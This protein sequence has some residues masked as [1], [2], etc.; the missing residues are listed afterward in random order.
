MM[1]VTEGRPVPG[2]T[3][4][5]A[6]VFS[7][8]RIPDA[9]MQASPSPRT[10]WDA[11]VPAIARHRVYNFEV[12][13]THTYIADGIRVHNRSTLSYID[14]DQQGEL[15]DVF[16]DEDGN[17][18][19]ITRSDDGAIWTTTGR[20]DPSDPSGNTTQVT[21]L[22]QLGFDENGNP[23]QDARFFLQQ[24]ETWI[25]D[26]NGD[27]TLSGIVIDDNYWLFGDEVGGGVGNV[28]TPFILEA[29]GIGSVFGRLTAGTLIDTFVQN[30]AEGGFN[31]LHHSILDATSTGDTAAF[32]AVD[33]FTDFGIDLGINAVE[34]SLS[35]VSELIM[36]EIFDSADLEGIPGAIMEAVVAEGIDYV[37]SA[38]VGTLLQGT[39]V[40]EAFD[41]TNYTIDNFVGNLPAVI[42]SAVLNELLPQAET[43]EGQIASSLASIFTAG[44]FGGGVGLLGFIGPLLGPALIG[45]IVGKI[46]DAIF[47]K[48][49]QAFAHL[50]F[51]INRG[52]WDTSF[53]TD[54]DGGSRE[55][56][57]QLGRAVN[58]KIN[59]VVEAIG[60]TS[61]NYD[62]IA[63]HRIG[64]YEEHWRNNANQN[65]RSG[66][67]AVVMSV[68][69]DVIKLM[70][71]DDGDLKVLRALDLANLETTLAGMSAQD[72]FTHIYSRMRF[73]Q[74][75]QYYL[76]NPEAVNAFIEAAPDS[77]EARAW[78]ATILAANELG[79]SD[80]YTANGNA[81][82]NFFA[83]GDGADVID[84]AGGNDEIR[85]YGGDDTLIGG[86]GDDEL[87]GGVGADALDGGAGVDTASYDDSGVAV[88]VDLST[89][90]GS[91]GEAA[92]DTYVSIE[93]LE[94]SVHGDD[95]T[96]DDAA[97][98]I[99]GNAGDDL[100]H[101]HG[102]DDI[103]RGDAGD[104]R[105]YGDLGADLTHAGAD[106]LEGGDGDDILHGGGGI[107]TVI[108]GAGHDLVSYEFA[109]TGVRISLADE[110]ARSGGQIEYFSEIEGAMG[111]AFG[112][113]LFGD[114]GANTFIG[115][116]GDDRIDGGAGSDTYVYTLG[117][118][119]DLIVDQDG[120]SANNDTLILHG[121][122]ADDVR[123]LVD[124]S[125]DLVI[126]FGNGESIFV[127]GQFAENQQ[128][129]L[130]LIQFDDG[131][132]LGR[133]EIRNKAA[134]DQSATGHVVG[135]DRIETYSHAE[136]DGSYAIHDWDDNGRTDRL[137]FTDLT[138]SQVTFGSN[139]DKDLILSTPGGDR[140]T[141]IGHFAEHL[142]T[143]I[144]EIEFSDG[145]VLN[146]PDIRNRSVAD[147]AATGFVFGTDFA[148][149]YIHT[150]GD[151]SYTITDWDDNGR[152]DRLT[153]T[154]VML[155]DV[156]FGW[157]NGGHLQ[158]SLANGERITVTG[159]FLED[160][161]SAIEE[162][163]FDDGTVLDAAAIRAR[164]MADQK[165]SGTVRGTDLADSYVHTPG[166]GSYTIRDWDDNGRTDRLTLTG[167]TPD[168]VILGATTGG[169]LTVALPGGDLIT[170][171]GQFDDAGQMGI[172][173]IAFDDGSELDRAAIRALAVDDQRGQG[174]IVGTELADTY[175]HLAG[176]GYLVLHDRGAAGQADTLV[177]ADTASSAVQFIR[178]GDSLRIDIGTGETI[179]V[180]GHFASNEFGLEAITFSDGVSLAR[181]DIPALLA[182]PA[183]AGS[184]QTGTD[185]DEVYT[186]TRGD[187]SYSITD[188][189]YWVGADR[190]TFADTTAD[191]VAIARIGNDVRI[192]LDNGEEITLV[193]Q[194]DTDRRHGVESIEFA[195]GVIWTERMLREEMVDAEAEAGYVR[196]T[197]LDETYVHTRGDGSYLI[198]DY[199]YWTGADRLRLADATAD[200][201]TLSR[202]GND[203]EITLDNGETITLVRQLDTDRRHGVETVEFSDGTVWTERQLRERM[204][205]DLKAQTI[206]TGTENDETYTHTTGDGSWVLSDYDYWG[207]AD[208]LEFSDVTAADVDFERLGNDVV[209]RLSMG[210]TVTLDRQLQTD[211][212]MGVETLTFADGTTM[213]R[214]AIRNRVVEDAK[215]TGRVTGTE[216]DETYVH[217]TGDGSYSINDYDYWGGA[218]RLILTDMLAS[219]VTL[220][221]IDT[222]LALHLSSG[223]TIT[224]E[225]QLNTDNRMGVEIIEFSDG[226]TWNR[227]QILNES[228][229][230]Q[231]ITGVIRGTQQD[232]TYSHAQGDGSTRLTDYDYWGGA[233]R[234]ILTDTFSADL[235][236]VRQGRNLVLVLPNDESITLVGQLDE[237]RRHQ[238]E[239][240]E[241]A[242]G[243]TWN[244]VRLRN[245]MV[246]QMKDDGVVWGTDQDETY[247]HT[248]G[249]GSY[250]L[251]DYDYWRGAD[252]LVL[253]DATP[254]DVVVSRYNNDAILTFSNG[255]VITL[256]RQLDEDLRHGIETFEFAD[257]TV[258][259]ERAMRDRMV[260]DAKAT[261]VVVGTQNDET[262]RHA[263]G[264]GSYTITEYDYWRGND[265]L[266]FEGLNASDV[267]FGRDGNDLILTV[268]GGEEIRIIR[269]LDED[270]R[271]SMERIEFADGTVLGAKG[272]R[273]R[274]VSDMKATGVVVGTEND[275]TYRHTI[276][277]GSYTL[278]DYD[279]WRGNDILVFT[280]A[281]A[282]DVTFVRSGNDLILQVAGGE[283]I[284]VIRQF[285]EDLRQS[286]ER[287]EFA[288]GTA[289]GAKG[290]RDRMVADAKPS[291]T[292]VGTEND[293]TYLHTIGD[294]SY[295]ISDY[296]YWQ[297]SDRLVFSDATPDDIVLSRS[298]N[299]L[300]ITV[301]GVDTITLL[302]HLDS[303]GRRSIETFEFSDGTTWS[304][305]QL[306]AR[307][308]GDMKAAGLVV[309]TTANETVV[310]TT[311]EGSYVIDDAASGSTGD[312]LE[313]ADQT[314]AD[315]S[316]TRSGTD[317]VLS[318]SNGEVITIRNQFSPGL[319]SA[320]ETIRFSDGVEWGQRALRDAIVAEQKVTGLVTGTSWSETFV[321]NTGDGSYTI[322]SDADAGTAGDELFLADLTRDEVVVEADGIDAILTT[323]AG[324]VIRLVGQYDPNN[325]WQ[326]ASVR[327]SDGEVVTEI[328]DLEFS[329]LSG[330]PDDETIEGTTGDDIFTPGPGNDLM[331][332]NHG[333]DTYHVEPGYGDDRIMEWGNF[334]ND[335]MIF[336]AGITVA[337][338]SARATDFDGNGYK[339][340]TID[341]AAGGSIT[342]E[343]VF[344]T[345]WW[346]HE[347]H[348]DWFEFSDGTVLSHEDFYAQ[349]YYSGTA[350]NDILEGTL[351]SDTFRGGLG[352][353]YFRGSHGDDVYLVEVGQGDDRLIE[354]GNF[355]NDTMRFGAGIT[356]ADLSAVVTDVDANGHN[357][358][359][360]DIAGGGSITLLEVFRTDWWAHDRQVDWYEFE[361][362]TRLSHE[363]FYEAVYFSGT[364][365]NDTL[366]GTLQSDTFRG[367]LGDDYFRGS[368][369]DDV[370]LVEAG[371]GD[372]RL[373]EWGNFNNDTMRFGAGITV[374]DLS[375][376]A[377]DVDA[378]GYKD[379]R[380][381]IAGGGSITLL[382]VFRTDWWAH[383][384]QV[385]WYEFEDGTR[386]SHEAFYEAVYFSGTA[387]ND[388]LEGTM[389]S[390]TFR[391]GLGD[392]YFRGSHG[393]DV[394]LVEAGQGDDRL[395]EW[396]NFQNDTMRF[397]A[398]ITLDN[399]SFEAVD[400]DA[401]GY[402][403]LRITLDGGGSISLLEIFRTDWWAHDRHVDW[404]E[405]EDG[406]R[407]THEQFY[408]QSYFLGTS[409]SETIEGT[410]QN[411]TF[412][413]SAGDD[414]IRG[415]HGN[416]TYLVGRDDGADRIMEWGNFTE[417]RMIFDAGI[418]V[419]DIVTTRTDVDANG[420]D[421]LLVTF[422]NGSGSVALLEVFRTDWW[423]H[424][425]H[426]D[427]FEF[428]DGTVLTHEQFYDL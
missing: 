196:G 338:L 379:L 12:E 181:A 50:E 192:T 414:Y 279:Y 99:S 241:F 256:L 87:V 19:V 415:N 375:A 407:L 342:I 93:N 277:D 51:D 136:G 290:I 265:T 29:V 283:E 109:P 381:D 152:T 360:I 371:Q 239:T 390:D 320:I 305:S 122:A 316:F 259:T 303:D 53:I 333:N 28:L 65:F 261:G 413:F 351:Q 367:G 225:Q 31:V 188:Y 409:G 392:D 340:L 425:R 273:D 85:T 98:L 213:G 398:G 17:L 6:S 133:T 182:T 162:I 356:V 74:D 105:I 34:T 20:T 293:E 402:K 142:D 61:H 262:Y 8:N 350:G 159:H 41:P 387:G 349:V 197:E 324:E 131:Q 203:L 201:I 79:L 411:D 355:N 10:S 366:E 26:E 48:D 310:H 134:E 253:T 66:D 73:A 257:G 110:T 329:G 328:E 408:A 212:R 289:L 24:T 393:D 200:Q 363:A 417:D 268:A 49:P 42:F 412:T 352:D 317:A 359:R 70:R 347:R 82:D 380:I 126:S 100:L 242:D 193:R 138:A 335:R 248:L 323:D 144:E 302:R 90:V 315:I 297:G 284:R 108:G 164:T 312:R 397:G 30:L 222:D 114:S 384:R 301:G 147:Q 115:L 337:D 62:S 428:A 231:K 88:T 229:D 389:Q 280:D 47:D 252:R 145:T 410:M 365:G 287:I 403:D 214:A 123:F 84:G 187:G 334:Q 116:A 69:V 281:N 327:F 153:L 382:E 160:Q 422:V 272:I 91:G 423:A 15:I 130:E 251:E 124:R 202:S 206:A 67:S 378:N 161:R 27:E 25:G 224:L 374:A 184:D 183:V 217:D 33:A 92:G 22:Y 331:R 418:D 2:Q 395:I 148:E 175:T 424:D 165:A 111:S 172:E 232:E 18:V 266:I 39:A 345:D 318:L 171:L 275:E 59:E 11:G 35:L 190:L 396:G 249:D 7:F 404:F 46:F 174:R 263:V 377:T 321:H 68:A 361:D 372:D 223:E 125:Q 383:D 296:D 269:Q 243:E 135:A 298:G 353:D 120:N 227:T 420:H 245:E 166:D 32:L 52:I 189:D 81:G 220:S 170:I 107:D 244:G 103:L 246:A 106:T 75:Y 237:D 113:H 157:L 247:Y 233:D 388:T 219:D 267:T 216:N 163:A 5:A 128:S 78:V 37:L 191:Q 13:G 194:L 332:G 309:G 406:T 143:A 294:G 150:P 416:D 250:T 354:W 238:I 173:R 58:E 306:A 399:L 9:V 101:G 325:G 94:G 54:D 226:S 235:G 346:A 63:T 400:V 292:V 104:D 270:L 211:N 156:T 330:S 341:F 285:D 386:L 419:S 23:A 195:D 240:V 180:A 368:H 295:S 343:E 141:I 36:A 89:G 158:I 369:G 209:I 401:N 274:M 178:V 314:A 40:G 300:T 254:G 391:G 177:L 394:Y 198:T 4:D 228:V 288:D 121:V 373:I 55:L 358:L 76:E 344:R 154:G 271:H 385:D 95:L 370:Y 149:S 64:H 421:D 185:A 155:A 168:Q 137:V 3:I 264:D 221:R 1:Q 204:V 307:L 86:A 348:V 77:A 186:H 151:G 210:E 132:T 326:L 282:G 313:F 16:E 236:L 205:D 427:W 38:G 129:G 276:G 119:T 127:S 376:V 179:T 169:A 167:V 102:G 117:D 357:D 72:A 208:R 286:L 426:V 207:G 299:D 218:D 230:A 255:D 215:V 364:A 405:F 45:A 234:L 56:A 362:G 112:D 57:S 291:G 97:N 21:K 319:A 339:D 140:I 80:A 60:A 44:S 146:L 139:P 308:V 322:N 96:G 311:G 118:G 278:T 14:W 71:A 336:A 199:D 304:K 176:D 258:W 260:A 83:T 43:P